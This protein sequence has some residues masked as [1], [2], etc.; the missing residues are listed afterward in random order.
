MVITFCGH[1]DYRSTS[2]DRLKMM[3][4]LEK[5]IGD[6][7]AELYFGG[8]GGFDSFALSC[9]RKYQE[10][11]PN[12]KLIFVTPYMTESYQKNQLSQYENEYD[13][14]VYPPLEKV[15]PKFAIL[16][17]NEW[18][19]DEADLLIACVKR[20]W[21]GAYQT[22]E[23]AI[24][25]KKPIIYF[26][27]DTPTEMIPVKAN[28]A[29]INAWEIGDY[30][31][32]TLFSSFRAYKELLDDPDYKRL[33]DEVLN[34]RCDELGCRGMDNREQNLRNLEDLGDLLVELSAGEL[35]IYPKSAIAFFLEQRKNIWDL[36][37]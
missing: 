26:T 22:Y 3:F 2:E 23:Y 4:L 9:G 35:K 8:Y 25:R 7:D 16:S 10:T 19:I 6:N 30:R 1:S 18:M 11:H 29:L 27:K 20:H 15:P 34:D 14:I 31:L 28:I 24:R 13:S 36:S 21:G 33:Y 32:S 17:R 37:M 12:V 5:T